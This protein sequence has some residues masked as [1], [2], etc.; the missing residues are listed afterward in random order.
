MEAP[1]RWEE[2]SHILAV[3]RTRDDCDNFGVNWLCPS[4]MHR[5][6][7]CDTR[8]NI[9]QTCLSSLSIGPKKEKMEWGGEEGRRKAPSVK[10]QFPLFL[11]R[12]HSSGSACPFA[13]PPIE[14]SERASDKRAKPT[15]SQSVRPSATRVGRSMEALHWT[16][17]CLTPEPVCITSRAYTRL[18]R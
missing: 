18:T 8:M 13:G 11:T 16:Q 7:W 10:G 15:A 17:T 3:N 4:C 9:H 14:A 2:G 5:S 6:V 12:L 1:V